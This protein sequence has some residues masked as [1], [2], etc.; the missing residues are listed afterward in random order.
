MA[1]NLRIELNK[2]IKNSRDRI[3][4]KNSIMPFYY[5]ETV[6]SETP[7]TTFDELSAAME[8]AFKTTNLPLINEWHALVDECGKYIAEALQEEPMVFRAA[9]ERPWVVG[10]NGIYCLPLAADAEPLVELWKSRYITPNV[11][12]SL[13]DAFL[14][15]DDYDDDVPHLT[16]EIYKGLRFRLGDPCIVREKVYKSEVIMFSSTRW[17]EN[18]YKGGDP[19]VG[20]TFSAL[21]QQSCKILLKDQD[22]GLPS[23]TKLVLRGD[24]NYL[25]TSEGVRINL[26]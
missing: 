19:E 25:R 26:I 16:Y 21:R 12:R 3:E 22:T 9:S 10:S 6:I 24:D 5:D 8:K 13:V 20:Y 15:N 11:V 18:T 7:V 17:V 4:G 2:L 1:L 14:E 23:G